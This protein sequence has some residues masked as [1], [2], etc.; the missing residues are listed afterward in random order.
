MYLWFDLY[1]VKCMYLCMYVC[2]L[3]ACMYGV[4]MYLCMYVVCLYMYSIY[5]CI[6]VYMYICINV[7]NLLEYIY[8]S[9]YPLITL[10]F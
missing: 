8:I 1:Y 7:C 4:C 9:S 10:P 3:Y 6:Y 2:M 5:V